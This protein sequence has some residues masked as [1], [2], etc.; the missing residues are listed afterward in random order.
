[1]IKKNN[2]I[3]KI[4]PPEVVEAVKTIEKWTSKQ[5][6]RDDWVIGGVA[7]G[8]GFKRLLKMYNELKKDVG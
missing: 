8:K 2:L 4:P 6:D 1:M 3:P 5:T 7:S